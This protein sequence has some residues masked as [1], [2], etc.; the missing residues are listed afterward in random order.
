LVIWVAPAISGAT[1][2]TGYTVTATDTTNSLHGGQTCTSSTNTS[3][4]VSSL[5][6]GDTYTFAVTATNYSGYTSS[7]SVASNAVV[8]STV[9]GAPTAVSAIRGRVRQRSV[10]PRQRTMVDPRSR[11]TR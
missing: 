9:P 2:I 10:G 4:T 3:C 5:T 7:P 1:A 6:L 8:P 11:A